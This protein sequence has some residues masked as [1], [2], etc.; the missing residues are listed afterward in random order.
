MKL[1]GSRTS[2]VLT[3]FDLAPVKN[4]A[5][6]KIYWKR[7]GTYII[8]GNRNTGKSALIETLAERHKTIIDLYGSKDN[9]NLCWCRKTSPID[10]ILL[11]HGENT[12]VDAPFDTKPTN[13]LTLNDL[14]SYEATV[15]CNSFFSSDKVKFSSLDHVTQCL[16]QRSEWDEGDLIFM[17][18][19]ET[20]D[21]LYSRMTTGQ[22]EKDAKVAFLQFFRQLRHYGVSVGADILRWTGV[23]KELRD[24]SEYII[25]KKLGWKGLPRDLRFINSYVDPLVFRY[26]KNNQCVILQENG[27]IALG[28]YG[29]PKYHKEEGVDLLKEIGITIEHDEELETSTTTKVGDKEHAKM[30]ELYNE[31]QSMK[32]VSEKVNRSLSTISFH[33]SY[34]NEQIEEIGKCPRCARAK[35]E[36]SAI[37]IHTTERTASY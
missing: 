28:K 25:F 33:V 6:A 30:I 15:T 23:D 8:M 29:L 24:L 36:L 32:V 27:N 11:I 3:D 34:H 9:E 18:F 19:R 37:Q 1:Y 17:A 5:K 35:S 13:E 10:D 14:L 16:E 21:L 22:G 31:E 26:M 7:P 4:R 2:D 20:M 12:H